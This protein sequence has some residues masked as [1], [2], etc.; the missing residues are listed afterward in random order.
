MKAVAYIRKSKVNPN[1]HGVSWEVQE[2]AV[3]DLATR[4][5]DADLEIL[6]DWGSSGAAAA[7]VFGGTTRGGKRR[8]WQQLVQAIDDGQVSALYAYSLS[9]LARSTKELL[10]LAERCAKTGVI[11]RLAKEGTL[12][13]MSATGRLYL[14]VLAGVSTFEAE[15]SAE[16][17]KDH[18]ALRRS[19]G[20][21]IGQAPYG[22]RLV[23]GKLEADPREPVDVVAT[24]FEDAGTY[25]GAAKLL[26][27]RGVRSKVGRW[28]D[29]SVRRVLG[30]SGAA[31]VPAVHPGRPRR[32]P[33]LLSG[34]LRCPCGTI[35][36]PARES[37]SLARGG[38]TEYVAYICW[39]SRNEPDHQKTRK[40]SQSL[41]EPWIREEAAR[42]R[43]PAN[44]ASTNDPER[45]GELLARRQRVVDNYEDGLVSREQRDE[46]IRAIDEE[47]ERLSAVSAAV[48]NVPPAID[49]RWDTDTINGVLRAMWD[50]VEL[51]EQL[52]PFRAEWVV[53]EWRA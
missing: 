52:R 5:G 22:F 12:D 23:D 2:A 47:L 28:S 37:H 14:T 18:V 35:M 40:V 3:R 36:T 7:G 39:R 33:A 1:G 6:S 15:I 50:R 9:R 25:N 45:H 43:V 32:R 49:W 46:K 53:P 26:N 30:R 48:L 20:D 51:D 34:L 21:H 41:L 8:I 24:A 27:S 29:M 16:R 31:A 10:E 17:A 42:L 19:R 13:F 38:T 11:V 4:Q 44:V